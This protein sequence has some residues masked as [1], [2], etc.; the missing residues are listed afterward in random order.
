MNYC[1][2]AYT[3]YENDFRVRR[4][5]DSM[6]EAGHTVDVIVLRKENDIALEKKENVTIHRIQHRRFNEKKVIQYLFRIFLFL[7]KSTFIIA[8]LNRRKKIDILHVHN[9]PDFLIFA[10]I[11]PKLYGA[12]LIL[13]IHD[14][15]PELFC[16]RLSKNT[17]SPLCKLLLFL[18]KVSVD[19]SNHVIIA[20]HLWRDKVIKRNKLSP[21]KCTA[22]I[23]FPTNNFNRAVRNRTLGPEMKLLYPG[24]L[25]CHHGIDIAVR[26]MKI[27]NT[28]IPRATLH[29]YA[30]TWVQSFKDQLILLI[31]ELHLEETVLLKPAVNH[32]K[33]ASVFYEADIGI[34]PKRPGVFSSE[35]FSTKIL[36]FMAAGIPIVAS[37]T[38]IDEYYFD[39]SMVAFFEGENFQDMAEQVLRLYK[40]PQTVTAMVQKCLEFTKRNNWNVRKTMFLEIA[41]ALQG[42][43]QVVVS[44]EVV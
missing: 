39:D 8:H 10:G 28:E 3:M 18:E 15:T 34:V 23:N 26:A 12:S 43:G 36:E 24:H 42:G 27:I 2:L 20:N 19:F 16:Q 1:V 25:S 17:D 6:A 40:Q 11:V 14:I 35:A 5:V 29:I 41:D 33:L 30:S 7:V 37:R 22:I 38:T 13:D 44:S 21:N 4:Y 31:N 9:V 32:D